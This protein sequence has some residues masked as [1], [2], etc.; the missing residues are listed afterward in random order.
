[1]KY[2][3]LIY[4]IAI[5]FVS[6][7][8]CSSDNSE[9]GTME[10]DQ[11]DGYKLT[12]VQ[13]ESSGMELGQMTMHG[14][15]EIVKA[16][17]TVDVPPEQHAAVSSYFGGTVKSIKLL[18]GQKVSK[19]QVLFVLENPD[20]VQIQQDYLEAVGR[21]AYLKSDYER[22]KNLSR[23]SISSQK[24]FLKAESDYTVTK[25]RV[26][27]L[28]KKL[29]L[30]NIDP[31]TLTLD[32]IR[33]TIPIK[34]PI[35]GYVSQVAISQGAYLNPSQ[36][37]VYVVDTDHLHLEL[38]IFEKDL[39]K[40]HTG[41]PIWF[42][43]QNDRGKEHEAHVYLINKIVDHTKR[44]V[45]IHGHL[46]DE[47]HTENFT[48]GLYVEADIY[49]ATDTSLSLPKDAL[50]EVDGINYV[51]VLKNSS[52]GNYTFEKKEVLAGASDKSNVEILNTKDFNR[53][54]KFLVRGAFNLI[55]E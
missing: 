25:V 6:L 49:T 18:P 52:N 45:S 53:D 50:V 44:T 30:M 8:A 17:G 37:A 21:L 33:T 24:N 12:G 4:V 46:N 19:G 16:T 38:R 31:A 5:V 7:T 41:Q 42:R 29:M 47:D 10:S 11:S 27:S 55:V 48:P 40:V 3:A 2:N 36:L 39:S 35:N 22:Q 20:Y 32:N 28:A 1:M 13:F 51:L 26:G 23:D 34:S 14:F 43:V 15:H 54:D 9:E